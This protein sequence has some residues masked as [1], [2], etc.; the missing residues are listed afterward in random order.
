VQLSVVVAAVA[1]LQWKEKSKMKKEI[2]CRGVQEQS[3]QDDAATRQEQSKNPHYSP[4]R[5]EMSQS[6]PLLLQHHLE[7]V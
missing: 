1:D 5:E 6:V 7:M 4:H 3:R 2:S